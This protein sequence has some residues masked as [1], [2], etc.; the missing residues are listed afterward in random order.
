MEE[1]IKEVQMYFKTKLLS[2]DFEIEKIDEFNVFL[3]I[4]NKYQFVVW[5]GNW[6]IPDTRELYPKDTFMMFELTREERL[7]LHDVLTDHVSKYRNEILLK[8]K[9]ELFE[10][11]KNE[12]DNFS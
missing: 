5:I 3:V 10:K 12:L 9:N 11:L 1:K 4:D 7:K 8:E 6:D 2:N